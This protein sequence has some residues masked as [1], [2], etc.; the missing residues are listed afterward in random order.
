VGG[1]SDLEAF[2]RAN[3]KGSVISFPSTI[4]TYISIHD[5]RMG[6]NYLDRRYIVSYSKREETDNVSS[7]KNDIARECFRFLE[8]PPIACSFTSDVYSEGSGLASSS[9]Y[10]I[11]LL[12][13]LRYHQ[14]CEISQL[15][16][17]NEALAL[18]RLF[19][20]ITGRQDPLGCGIGALKRIDFYRDHNTVSYLPDLIFRRSLRMFLL[21]TGKRRSSTKLLKTLDLKKI[22]ALMPLV[23]EMEKIL[24]RNDTLA[25]CE[26]VREGWRKKKEA[27][28]EICDI[29]LSELDQLLSNSKSILAHRLC[30]AGGGGYFLLF[31]K[32]DDNI[33][34]IKSGRL[35]KL[36]SSQA[37]EIE[38]DALGAQSQRI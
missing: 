37:I 5:D 25:F 15:E 6:I 9:A 32:R 33:E 10:I 21:Y 28:S 4:Y 2:I 29:E 1:S 8:T 27:S 17:C 23:D 13:A 20:P 30:G 3:G 31:T 19:N 12:K 24:Y 11:A 38:I 36:F 16:L 14:R 34:S 18:E 26:V 7:I 22:E 35:A